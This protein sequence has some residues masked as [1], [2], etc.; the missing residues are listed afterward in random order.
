MRAAVQA[1]SELV[2]EVASKAKQITCKLIP[3]DAPEETSIDLFKTIFYAIL[4][5]SNSILGGNASE[6]RNGA[7]ALTIA[8]LL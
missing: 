4:D 8:G 1:V 2:E 5:G 6:G 3:L 7:D